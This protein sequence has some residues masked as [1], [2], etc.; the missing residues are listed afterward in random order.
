M[1]SVSGKGQTV[2]GG[3]F[4]GILHRANAVRDVLEL[5]KHPNLDDVILLTD[6][7]SATAV[8][9]LLAKVRGVICLSGGPTSHLAIVSREF[10]LPCV[11]GAD[12]PDPDQLQGQRI[13]VD[14]HGEITLL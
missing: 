14:A 9:P 1:A 12:I 7:P 3:E 13:K 2:S 5:V 11:M 8:V 4:E 10:A 6:S